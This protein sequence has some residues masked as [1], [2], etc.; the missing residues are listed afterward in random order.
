MLSILK[1]IYLMH[2][3]EYFCSTCITTD[4]RIQHAFVQHQNKVTS[5]VY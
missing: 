1:C 4:D 5:Q 3:T 2:K